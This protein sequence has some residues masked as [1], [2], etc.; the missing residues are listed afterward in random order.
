MTTGTG[1]SFRSIA[2]RFLLMAA[3]TIVFGGFANPAF[4]VFLIGAAVFGLM[5]MIRV[6]TAPDGPD[7]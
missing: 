6:D 4:P 2:A 7:T 3:L 1:E 5:S